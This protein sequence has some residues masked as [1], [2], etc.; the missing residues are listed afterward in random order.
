MMMH[1]NAH[2]VGILIIDAYDDYSDF[3]VLTLSGFE[4]MIGTNLGGE[5]ELVELASK[6]R[7]LGAWRYTTKS[8]WPRPQ[9]RLLGHTKLGELIVKLIFDTDSRTFS[10]SRAIRNFRASDSGHLRTCAMF[11][12]LKQYATKTGLPVEGTIFGHA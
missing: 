12:P 6:I 2:K 7:R 5:A 9:Q 11:L 1:A 10:L 3:R 4:S 8:V